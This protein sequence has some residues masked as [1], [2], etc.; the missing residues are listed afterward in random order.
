MAKKEILDL[1]KLSAARRAIAQAKTIDEIKE[2]R[3]KAEAARQYVKKRNMGLDAQNDIAEIVIEAEARA[4]QIIKEMQESGELAKRGGDR[5]SKTQDGCLK[6]EDLGIDDH[7]AVRWKLTDEVEPSKREDYYTAQREKT[8]A[9]TSNGVRRIALLARAQATIDG[10]ASGE[11]I[12]PEGYFDVIVIDPPWPIQKIEREERPNQVRLDYPAMTEPELDVLD[13]PCAD[14]C[15]VWLWTTH[16]FL[17]M[18]FRLLTSWD[19]KYVCTFV[20]HK[21]G[22]FQPIGLPQYNC[23]FAL[24]A[25]RGAPKFIDTK[26]FNTC[27]DAPRGDHSEKPEEFYDVVRRVT[28]GRRLDMFN[29]RKIEGFEGHGYEAK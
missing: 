29:R 20:W 1:V 12:A 6:I 13:V 27:F 9:I 11:I 2:I 21:P 8:E 19:I 10:I 23:E 28:G 17:P 18:A 26:K 16:R 4:G 22:G 24:Y 25:R 14:D 7:Q 3:D 5:K 15:H